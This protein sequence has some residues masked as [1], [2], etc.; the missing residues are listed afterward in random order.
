MFSHD[1]CFCHNPKCADPN[2]CRRNPASLKDYP[3][4]VSMADLSA[5]DSDGNCANFYPVAEAPSEKIDE[6][7]ALFIAYLLGYKLPRKKTKPKKNTPS[8]TKTEAKR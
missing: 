1:I 7:E 2:K 6:A 5:F 4:P 3:Y 8:G